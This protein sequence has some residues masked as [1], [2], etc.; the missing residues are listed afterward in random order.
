MDSVDV[1]MLLLVFTVEV[2]RGVTTH[3][4]GVINIKSHGG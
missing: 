3:D 1:V 2:N 4:H